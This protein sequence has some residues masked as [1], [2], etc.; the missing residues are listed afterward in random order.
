M[1]GLMRLLMD[2]GE[3]SD[4]NEVVRRGVEDTKKLGSRFFQTAKL[5]Q[6]STKG[7]PRRQIGGMLRESRL[8][9]THR[10]LALACPPVLFCK[11]RKSNRRRILQDP[12]SEVF[13]PRVVGHPYIME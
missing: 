9:H 6:G 7:H 4:G 8:A 10:F 12:A 1:S 11:L 2:L 5:E 13:N 3:L